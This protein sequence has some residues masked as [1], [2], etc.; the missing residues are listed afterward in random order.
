M[1]TPIADS[2]LKSLATEVKKKFDIAI[3]EGD[4]FFYPSEKVTLQESKDTGVLWQI[5][6][7]PA[8][9]K[10]PKDL[11]SS[12]STEEK[13][14]EEQKQEEEKKEDKPQQNKSD[15]FAPPYVPNLLVKELG[16]DH[17][18]LLNKFCVVPQHFLMVTKEFASQELP[19]SPATLALAYRIVSAHRSGASNTELLSFYNCGQTSGA[20][21]PHRHLQFVQCPRS[22]RRAK[23][24]SRRVESRK[25][26]KTRSSTQSTKSP[27]NRYSSGSKRTAKRNT[28]FMRCLCHGSTL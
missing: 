12:S 15:V 25:K 5:R 18:M 27:L 19:P 16:E 1:P 20:S 23:K 2:E 13:E 3:A 21:Q 6:T 8:L 28:A 26:S 17:V 11:K 14:E 9:L 4:A 22:T 7:V 24:Q 10:K